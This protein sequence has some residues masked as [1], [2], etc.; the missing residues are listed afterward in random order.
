MGQSKLIDV[1][2]NQP[3][4]SALIAGAIVQ[5]PTVI[6]AP[7]DKMAA[8]QF[9]L[10]A[11]FMSFLSCF[12]FYIIK[13]FLIIEEKGKVAA[14]NRIQREFNQGGNIARLYSYNIKRALRLSNRLLGEPLASQSNWSANSFD[15]CLAFSTIYPIAAAFLSWSIDPETIGPISSALGLPADTNFVTKSAFFVSLFAPSILLALPRD[16]SPTQHRP[17][18]LL[19]QIPSDGNEK[20]LLDLLKAESQQNR[21]RKL[22]E[23]A[24]AIVN[25]FAFGALIVAAITLSYFEAGIAPETIRI[26]VMLQFLIIF[27]SFSD[28]N[29]FGL[30]VFFFVVIWFFSL[31][32]SGFEFRDSNNYFVAPFS[33]IPMLI[34]LGVL[35]QNSISLKGDKFKI[36][37][38]TL[39]FFP[40]SAVFTFFLNLIFDKDSIQTANLNIIFL[41]PL[42]S[43]VNALYDWLSI[44]L[45]RYLIRLGIRLGGIWPLIVAI[46]D[47]GV[48]LFLLIGLSVSIIY[49]AAAFTHSAQSVGLTTPLKIDT[50]I[51]G[52]TDV[53][54]DVS[55]NLWVYLI[56][57]T[58][59]IPSFLNLLV[60][61]LALVRATGF[62]FKKIKI[63]QIFNDGRIDL[64]SAIIIGRI[65]FFVSFS[66][67]I[68]LAVLGL[69]LYATIMFVVPGYGNTLLN[70]VAL[71][72]T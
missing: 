46:V 10:F 65:S 66:L 15:R 59:L 27:M 30:G 40:L 61:C 55:G 2:T 22:E 43:I 69:G 1:A 51:G 25:F 18:S 62:A 24:Y 33:I 36:L 16:R 64:Y 11:F 21:E 42:L 31:T 70:V 68:S 63:A 6:F 39:C 35:A 23:S 7:W 48:G 56:I 44:G 47:I 20:D 28:R 9:L 17:S 19:N 71:L 26:I 52:Y 45:T 13:Y 29:F 34:I 58:T 8:W 67:L 53:N 41:L 54:Q 57:F 5:V 37:L 60:G 3:L 12:F 4:A 49:T 14:Q 32:S 72:P 38:I 50:I